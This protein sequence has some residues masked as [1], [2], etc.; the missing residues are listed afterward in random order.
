MLELIC[1]EAA[2]ALG[3]GEG[4]VLPEHDLKELGFDSLT[5][6]ELRNRIAAATGVRPAASMILRS[7][8]PLAIYQ[9]L[10]AELAASGAPTTVDGPST[11]PG[12]AEFG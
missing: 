6:I 12:E 9:R 10:A 8:T 2:G 7:R 5:A 4:A 3:Y 11:G 1:A